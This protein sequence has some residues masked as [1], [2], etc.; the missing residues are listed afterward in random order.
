MDTIEN[1][2]ANYQDRRKNQPPEE[3]PQSNPVPVEEPIRKAGCSRK[4]EF[5]IQMVF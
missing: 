2:N 1:M 4:R 3:M 5:L